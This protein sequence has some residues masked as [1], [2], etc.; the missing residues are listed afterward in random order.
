VPAEAKKADIEPLV[1]RLARAEQMVRAGNGKLVD[2]ADVVRAFNELMAKI[3]APS[4]LRTDEASMRRFREHAASI[5]AFPVLFSADRNGTNCNPG[6]AVFLLD[7]LLSDDGVLYERNLD[8]AVALSQMDFQRNGG[9]RSFGVV[10]VERAPDAQRLLS[11]YVSH[12]NRNAATT[13]FNDLAG[14]LGF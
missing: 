4:S 1:D 13:L 12:H 10:G 7:L 9:G 2:E 11:S 8:S 6:E 3:G 14:V 5:R